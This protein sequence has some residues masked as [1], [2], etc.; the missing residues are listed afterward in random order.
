[1]RWRDANVIFQLIKEVL[2][3]VIA[4]TFINR[5]GVEVSSIVKVAVVL[6]VLILS[7]LVKITVYVRKPE[8]LLG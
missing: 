2:L 1:M 3:G 6:V 5:Q 8:I 7:I 4:V